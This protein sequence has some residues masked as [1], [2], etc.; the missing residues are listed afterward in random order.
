MGFLGDLWDSLSGK[1]QKKANELAQQQLNM[2]QEQL[3]KAEANRIKAEIQADAEAKRAE[4]ERLNT[5]SVKKNS[6]TGSM[7]GRFIQ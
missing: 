2:Q 4:E 3:K 5:K 7:W 1:N 6:T